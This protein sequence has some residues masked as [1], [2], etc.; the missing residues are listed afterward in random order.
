MI[1]PCCHHFISCCKCSKNCRCLH[2]SCPQISFLNYQANK[3][4]E[5][6]KNLSYLDTK[7]NLN[8][9]LNTQNQSNM[10]QY[11]CFDLTETYTRPNSYIDCNRYNQNDNFI[12][13][14]LN[15]INNNNKNLK[16]NLCLPRNNSFNYS[17][18]N[19]INNNKFDI[20][21]YNI[22]KTYNLLDKT[23]C[24][25]NE[26]N[27]D[28]NQ[29]NEK[30]SEN[31]NQYNFKRITSKENAFNCNKWRRNKRKD[32]HRYIR[33]FNR[34]NYLEEMKKSNEKEI[35]LINMKLK[36][37]SEIVNKRNLEYKNIINN[38]KEEKKVN[39]SNDNINQSSIDNNNFYKD[40]TINRTINNY[41]KN[42]VYKEIFDIRNN[43]ENNKYKCKK[44]N[45]NLNNSYVY[46]ENNKFEK[47]MKR[48]SSY[49][50]Y[51]YKYKKEKDYVK[52][53][54]KRNNI[55]KNG[56]NNLEN[57]EK[58]KYY[59]K[60]KRNSTFENINKKK[61]YKININ[62]YEE[63]NI[64]D[65]NNKKYRNKTDE[66]NIK[67]V[68][69]EK[70]E[71]EYN[72]KYQFNDVDIDTNGIIKKH[73]RY[74]GDS[75]IKKNKNNCDDIIIDDYSKPFSKYVYT[76]RNATNKYKNIFY[77]E[78]FH[79]NKSKDD[80]DIEKINRPFESNKI[81]SSNREKE[82]NNINNKRNYSSD[83]RRPI[84]DDN[85]NNMKNYPININNI[86]N[87]E[88]NILNKD[89][90]IINVKDKTN[91]FNIRRVDKNKLNEEFLSNNKKQINNE[92]NYCPKDQ[93]NNDYYKNI[94]NNK[95][96]VDNNIYQKDNINPS[97]KNK[98]DENL[99]DINEKNYN[100]NINKNKKEIN[101]N[102]NFYYGNNFN[103]NNDSRYN[104]NND[105]KEKIFKNNK[106][107]N[108]NN[109]YSE[110]KNKNK[111]YN[112]EKLKRNNNDNNDYLDRY[113]DKE[114]NNYYNKRKNGSYLTKD[115]RVENNYNN[116]TQ[117]KKNINL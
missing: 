116:I 9:G 1:F 106:Y 42:N 39:L 96:M 53:I 12:N 45:E 88:S 82:K 2:N 4:R 97:F 60:G 87:N 29:C 95:K 67:L 63:N 37:L 30:V 66:K 21:K 103:I 46:H 3:L 64:R 94:I 19:P 114:S 102:Y 22:Y 14:C 40:E 62:K 92:I 100:E 32:M 69:K 58:V 80:N 18:I 6:Q 44:N 28:I 77:K 34:K 61:E 55:K 31:I 83:Y 79:K 16:N 113:V 8:S 108:N 110:K 50:S 57:K 112:N 26:S 74:R 109:Y 36:F 17:Y 76:N 10:N 20:N 38:L 115:K 78:I 72:Y 23:H 105:I 90:N 59:Y 99:N 49:N 13:N 117:K 47:N 91:I 43:Y 101:E 24:I 68:N 35:K 93:N 25:F 89:N 51:E 15:Q 71:E 70:K 84:Y 56:K 52:N 81:F 33:D 27:N 48:N 85:E 107:L 5:F 41:K 11:N 7:S 73:I 54:S 65:F 86:K 75:S 98:M 111:Y 104:S